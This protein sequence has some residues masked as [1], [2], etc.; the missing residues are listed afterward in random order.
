MSLKYTPENNIFKNPLIKLANIFGIAPFYD[1]TTCKLTHQGLFKAYGLLLA[2][3]MTSGTILFYSYSQQEM[4]SISSFLSGVHFLMVITSLSL[5]SIVILGSSFWH[6]ESWQQILN[7]LSEMEYHNRCSRKCFFSIPCIF[8]ITGTIHGIVLFTYILHFMQASFT[9]LFLPIIVLQYAIL[10]VV[11]LMM[12]IVGFLKHMYTSINS[13]LLDINVC[14]VIKGN[15]T[16]KLQEAVKVYRRAGK[17]VDLFNKIFG[18]PLLLLFAQ[19]VETVLLSLA[20]LTERNKTIHIDK[21]VPGE[22]LVLNT[23]YAVMGL[24]SISY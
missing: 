14:A 15:A 2:V 11:C 4:V 24:V 16:E 17:I 13:S 23:F 6:M 18:W 1:F 21:V 10:V 8:F 22:V 7:L 9:E 5:F 3:M 12:D 20:F 19:S